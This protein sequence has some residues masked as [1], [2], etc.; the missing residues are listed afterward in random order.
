MEIG[1][2]YFNLSWNQ[3]ILRI[4]AGFL[5]A[6]HLF[7]FRVTPLSLT[8]DINFIFILSVIFEILGGGGVFYL[9]RMPS[10][11][12]KELMS[13]TV[14]GFKDFLGFRQKKNSINWRRIYPFNKG[15]RIYGGCTTP[16]WHVKKMYFYLKV[17]TLQVVRLAFLV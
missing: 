13:L 14:K 11:C 16:F 12:Q 17:E 10:S 2:K 7:W 3:D 1:L 5:D 15:L 6:K 8:S 4:S 9:P